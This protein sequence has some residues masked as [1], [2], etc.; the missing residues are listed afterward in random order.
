MTAPDRTRPPAPGPVRPFDF[1]GVQR[2]RLD[3]DLEVLTAPHG[4]L[5][6]VTAAL[7]LE[8]GV[9]GEPAEKAGVARLTAAALDAG[10]DRRAADALAGDLERLGV[11]LDTSTNW[12]ATVVSLT[13]PRERLAAALEILAE[14]VRQPAFPE[15]EVE[16][17]RDQQLAAILQRK[18]QPGAL[19]NDMAARFIF[20]PKTPYARPVVGTTESVR[21]LNRDDVEAF[22]RTHFLP[23]TSALLFVGDI[24]A[25]GA[26]GLARDYFGDWPAGAAETPDFDV[27][28]TVDS[29]EVFVVDRPGAVQSE[30]RMGHIGV[31]RVHEDYFPLRVMN[32][33]LGGA[34]TSRLNMTL[35]EKHGFTYGVRSGFAFRRRPGPFMVRTAVASDVTARAVQETLR[36]LRELQSDG[37]AEEEVT[38]ARDYLRGVL[39]LKLQTTEQLAARIADLVIY[40]LP[41][42]YFD[43]YRERIAAVTKIGRAHV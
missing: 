36:E 16:R 25:D 8:T 19:A 30:L 3:N 5:P 41:A 23:N 24:G 31:P 38:A 11:E 13:M 21:N 7:V 6:V 37:A 26:E 12:D 40:D 4:D 14:I 20:S 18:K 28:P 15:A 9:A 34:F 27:V 1:P 22:Y 29:S 17:L 10:T 35:R 2:G 32:T 33:L 42:D 43:H 39:P